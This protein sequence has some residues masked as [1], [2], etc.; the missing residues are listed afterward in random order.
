MIQ[1]GG[2]DRSIASD[3]RRRKGRVATN[4][5]RGQAAVS[6][7]DVP[8]TNGGATNSL[9]C[10]AVD[11]IRRMG[12]PHP[13]FLYNYRKGRYEVEGRRQDDPDAVHTNGR[14]VLIHHGSINW[15]R[16]YFNP[17]KKRCLNRPGRDGQHGRRAEAGGWERHLTG[18]GS[19]RFVQDGERR[20]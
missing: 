7:P 15:L 9:L 17:P 12:N 8:P 5:G 20:R 16:E 3:I 4:P 1:K 18:L 11:E 19:G 2:C 14:P 10:L 6:G 13:P